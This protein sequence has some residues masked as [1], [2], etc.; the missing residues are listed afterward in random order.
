MAHATALSNRNFKLPENDSLV[1]V[2]LP[3][4]LESADF[5]L[6]PA[7]VTYDAMPHSATFEPNPAL[8]FVEGVDYSIY[9]SYESSEG[10]SVWTGF[11]PINAGV[12][13][14][15]IAVH[16]PNYEEVEL[17]GWQMTIDRAPVTVVPSVTQSKVYDRT[18][19]AVASVESISGVVGGEDV[20]VSVAA[21]YDTFTTNA[22]SIRV[23]YHLTGEDTVNY[24]LQDTV[25]T[26]DGEILP[27]ELS[28]EGTTALD[29]S[30]DGKLDAVVTMGTL[31]S[32]ISPDEVLA[33][34]SSAVYASDTI[35]NG[36]DIYVAY[37]LSGKDAANYTV[38][39]D[40]IKGNILEPPVS[41]AWTVYDTVYGEAVVGH[42]PKVDVVQT[43]DGSLTYFVDGLPVDTG[44]VIPVGTHTLLAQFSGEGGFSIPSGG[45]S[46]HVSKKYLVLDAYD[47]NLT[48]AYDGTDSVLSLRTDSL[49][50][51]V[52][53]QDDVRLSSL[54]ARYN[55]AQVGTN[56]VVTVRLSLE[57]ADTANYAIEDE[58][59]PGV[60][61]TREVK[62]AAGDSTKVYDGTPLVFDSVAIIGDGFIEG[63]L[64]SVHATGRIVEP[65][66]E[67]NKVVFEFANDSVEDN[68]KI[69]I[70]RGFLVIT[71]IPQDAPTV[72]PVDESV[73]GF[74]DGKILGLTTSMEMRDTS[75]SVFT[76]VTN[77]DSLFAPGT[78]YVRFPELQY[79]E[80]SDV[81]EVTILPGPGEFVVTASSS[82]TARGKAVGSGTYLY[83]TQVVIDATA[84]T[85]YHF[86]AWNDTIS[87]N[88]LSFVLT[89]DTSF[90]ASFAPNA[91]ELYAK[92]GETTLD[93]L[94]VLFGDTVVEAMLNV[95]P[96]KVGY[97]FLGW[98]PSFPIVMG[99]GD[100]TVEAQWQRKMF[101]VEVDTLTEGGRIHPA[102]E[103]PVA[104]GDTVALTAQPA[105]GYHFVAWN[106]G[107]TSNPYSMVVTS[108]TS[109]SA[110]FAPNQ[111][112]LY[113]MSDGIALD[114]MV[115]TYGDTVVESMLNVAPSKVG[116]AF[117]GWSPALP[118]TVGAS[119]LIIE[120]QWTKQ[121]YV[122]SVDSLTLGGTAV[123]D[124]ENPVPYGDT[125]T[126]TAQPAEGYHFVAWSDGD[127]TNP[128]SVIVTSDS[129]FSPRFDLNHHFLF[130]V[131]DSTRLDSVDVAYGDTVSDTLIKVLP[132][133]IGFDFTG[134]SPT[135]PVVM[136]DS[137]LTVS[138]QWSPKMYIV[139][140]DTMMV[141]GSIQTNFEN[142][143]PYGT[144]AQLRAIPEDGY[145]FVSWTDGATL[146][147]RK[148]VVYA[149]SFFSATFEPSRYHVVALADGDTFWT[150][151]FR[152]MDTLTESVI[153][154]V[155]EKVGY[156]FTGWSPELPF[157]MG[158]GDTT[159][160]AL[161][162]IKKFTFDIDTMYEN[163][164]VSVDFENPV[165]YGGTVS[166][167]A[168]P[169]EGYHFVAWNDSVT[170][171][172]RKVVVVS[173]TSLTPL[174]EPNRYLLTVL[175]MGDTLKSFGVYY[176]DTVDASMVDVTPTL[177]GYDFIGWQPTLPLVMGASDQ[178][179]E[180]Q[181]SRKTFELT[182]DTLFD[183]GSVDVDFENPVAYGDTIT[184]TAEPS[185]GYHFVAWND[186]VTTNPRAIVVTGDTSLSPIFEPNLYYLIVMNEDT[187][188]QTS[189][190][191]YGDTIRD[192]FVTVTL[193]KVG[194]DFA[195]W[196]PS[197]PLTVG[198]GD[199]TIEAQW[200]RKSFELS[201]DTLY[202]NGHIILGFES[203]VLYGDTITL[204]A[205]PFEG[206]H[207]ISWADGDSLNPRSV[208]VV[209]D[210]SLS[211][212]FMPNVYLFS[213]LVDGDTLLKFNVTYGDTITDS[214]VNVIPV[215]VGHDFAGW[216]PSL[217]LRVGTED[218]SVVAQWTKKT[219]LVTVEA[220]VNGKVE[221]KFENPVA[222]GDTIE[223]SAIPDEGFRFNSWS[224]GNR[225]NPRKVKVTSD[226]LFS[227]S[228]SPSV[229]YLTVVSD[230]DTLATLPFH[231][232][233]SVMRQKIDSL[234][235][236][237]V[238]HNFVGWSVDFPLAME[239]HDTSVAAIFTPK[240]FSV[241]T[242][243]NG[244]VG[245]VIGQGEY[246]YDTV[247][248]LQAIPNE[249]FHFVKW[250]D[251]DTARTINFTI[252]SDTIV[253]TLFAMDVDE[254]MVD[255]LIIP[256]FGYCPNTEDVIRYSLLNS[257]APSEYRIVFSE[258]AKAAG[259]VDVDFTK[260]DADNE[261]KIVIPDCPADVY[262]ASIQFKNKINSV[263]PFFDVDLRVNLSN[264]YILDIWQDVVSVVNTE[265]IFREYQWYHNDV[266]VGGATLP[267]Y[268]EKK[269]LSGSYYLEA[270]TSDGRQLH[271]CKK[272][273]DNATNTTLSVYPNPTSDN[274]TVE[275]SVDNG[276]N[277][278]LTVTNA[279][280]VVVLNTTFVGRKTQVNFRDLPA[281][282]YV[283]EVDGL[284]VKEIK[285]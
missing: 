74:N 241:I 189:P 201:I 30:Y 234:Q 91:Y 37:Q 118:V 209:G 212:I 244:N 51:G 220:G 161:F 231:F 193:E 207:F 216:T 183:H 146:N 54:S 73:L 129:T 58:Q 272:W 39:P 245:K 205:E 217:P 178:T 71:K 251:G 82:D 204:T 268:C 114:T 61:R 218:L 281:G 156:D 237:K 109:I 179:I 282:T 48:K 14:I 16:N 65:G 262:R 103:N 222:Y 276:A 135:L 170:T 227:A 9:Y 87:E 266:K 8:Q 261:V 93:S 102:F 242:K 130:I 148:Y 235:P 140:V 105:E 149:D 284:T 151:P 142:P 128:R 117:T 202:E 77:P 33:S 213:A 278:R 41:F 271:T 27:L 83:G 80:A 85:G 121:T 155:P 275:L 13:D 125:I 280:G 7:A 10:A 270:I 68:Y 185:E 136:G 246:P 167:T 164:G 137:D 2:I 147:P 267:Y 219:Y 253:S 160:E 188:V 40:T 169:S 157:V 153:G 247:V 79:Y 29:K 34:V 263:T 57:G 19:D 49:L 223:F 5:E 56:K 203:P 258:E 26:T 150:T 211:P 111:Y 182:L 104:Y 63:D 17:T 232:K 257:E 126:L 198:T 175:S 195:G 250:G 184:L 47:I 173:D 112:N 224:D 273:F 256:S 197:L 269:G 215:K 196:L 25:Y 226:S 139:T 230:N 194:H 254:M 187:I 123:T 239:S 81:S 96:Q 66:H 176:G 260:I 229:Y 132:E 36:T 43:V 240:I 101:T 42:N 11:S 181:F 238:G 134:W 38:K 12:Y 75:D 70:A 248:N 55:S 99:A 106:V 53:G 210:T 145:H 28:V 1:W 172:P 124:F 45:K 86:V 89:G 94:S 62:L 255:T 252:T 283:V 177:E 95:L 221:R 127:A 18:S 265:N 50:V 152:Y 243:V 214:L 32:E 190:V 138:A 191:H 21:Q 158:I 249:G 90:V 107:E 165:S 274:A 174:F 163:G 24:I 119:D 60:I 88:P 52:V 206:Y 141:G 233:D 236:V 35:G 200:T 6:Q 131:S 15:K 20:S 84:Q 162:T 279:S 133:K 171:N 64:L 199:V 110:S 69:V 78:Y 154:A 192:S 120:A 168:E 46:I 72:T 186:S 166:L 180:A 277:H 113:V 31:Q 22:S 122:V 98:L 108:D 92:D 144:Y 4:G 23:V 59:L 228:F 97:D 116:Y 143:V 159:I 44:Y 115:V 208:V 264:D 100:T 285:K 67:L 76:M 3:K 259:F 225:S